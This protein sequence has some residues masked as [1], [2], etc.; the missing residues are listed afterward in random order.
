MRLI[1][2]EFRKAMNWAHTWLGVA[3]GVV[4]FAVF[5]MGSLTVFS[6][7]I[8]R[9]MIP[10]TRIVG[11]AD[12]I[13]YDRLLEQVPSE[14]R[15]SDYLNFVV[16]TDRSPTIGFFYRDADGEFQSL[17]LDPVTAQPITLTQ[18]EAVSGFI[19]PFHFTLTLNWQ[20]LGMWIVG[21]A[22]LGMLLLL[23]TG[24][25]IH[26]KIIAEFFVFRPQ[27]KA[28]RATLDLHNLTSLVG[29]PFYFMISFSGLL[30]FALNYL[31]WASGE[32]FNGDSDALYAELSG[33]YQP[34]ERTG[35]AAPL[36][37]LDAMK[38]EAERLWSEAEGR[39]VETNIVRVLNHGDE[40][41]VVYFR[42]TFPKDRVVLSKYVA[43]F[44]G[45]SGKLI[46]NFARPPINE[47]KGWVEGAH[48]AQVDHWPLRWLYFL[49]GLAGCTMIATGSLFWL[50]ARERRHEPGGLGFRVMEALTI[51]GTTGIIAATGA[52][53]VVNRVLPLDAGKLGLDRAG[54]EIAAFWAVWVA[55]LVHAAGL[56]SAA[57]AQQCWLIAGLA[58]AAVALNAATT[59]HNIIAAAT[60]SLWSIAIMDT[61]LVAVALVALWA[62]LRLQP[63]AAPAL[64]DPVP[65]PAE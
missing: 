34:G 26:R 12:T 63:H 42:N 11:K 2:E 15:D 20:S 3:L 7:E 54:L 6:Q 60:A 39:P 32:P 53:L 47:A 40:S 24:L 58:I 22:A 36:A 50:R 29:L 62:A 43:V 30:I 46:R 8:D 16:P 41:A 38:A 9:W 5:W 61:V 44:D 45:P 18:S 19:Y 51:A 4:L 37:S 25:F 48:F 17:E 65:A 64:P 33:A 52:F 13:S 14:A 10:E 31:P 23:A 57:W 1:T 59:G 21:F 49:G 28:R 35:R 27:R 56:R 55:T